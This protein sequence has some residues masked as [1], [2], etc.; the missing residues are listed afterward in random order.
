MAARRHREDTPSEAVQARWKKA[1]SQPRPAGS[2][3]FSSRLRSVPV[4]LALA[5]SLLLIGVDHALL[6]GA[7]E[8]ASPGPRPAMSGLWLAVLALAVGHG[9][10]IDRYLAL[11]TR[12]ER[13]FRLW[14]R[15]LRFVIA[16]LPVIGLCAIPGWR[17]LARK[18][19]RWAAGPEPS[20]DLAPS[21]FPPAERAIGDRTARETASD[22]SLTL[23]IIANV[24]LLFLGLPSLV[25]HIPRTALAVVLHL[26]VFAS[27]MPYVLAE[28]RRT[29]TARHR[30]AL[31]MAALG[32]TLVPV[33]FVPLG[34]LVAAVFLTP[35]AGEEALIGPVLE[36][37]H[38][39]S[40]A[41]GPPPVEPGE[42]ELRHELL[43]HRKIL[44]LPLEAAA[45]GWLLTHTALRRPATAE[46]LSSIL[47]L[48]KGATLILGA[49]GLLLMLLQLL[50]ALARDRI[51]W[52]LPAQPAYGRALAATQLGTYA[53][54]AI[55]EA[56]PRGDGAEVGAVI[57]VFGLLGLVLVFL[58]FFFVFLPMAPET[59]HRER[60]N[61]PWLLLFL[62]LTSMGLE[63]TR[64]DS[65]RE[66]AQDLLWLA[67]ILALVFGPGL[68]HQLL[69]ALLRPFRSSDTLRQ[70]LPRPL[71]G[72]ISF[73]RLTAILPLGGLAVPVWI[74]LRHHCRPRWTRRWP[75][76]ARPG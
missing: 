67:I 56:L 28:A 13:A 4:V 26:G 5:M 23:W 40:P 54:L 59:E 6:F 60:F 44:L 27:C 25:A 46:A 57:A 36:R 51:R 21:S 50:Q 1:R 75:P 58:R 62:G 34:G 7:P 66:R 70:E 22:R 33:P 68:G 19:P 48:A 3:L 73:L 30:G 35:R 41:G 52:L 61:V 74:Y 16:S 42:I 32:L 45:L 37:R 63:M 39:L 49:L 53:G 64:S 9:L 15:V 76:S 71:R 12:G 8:P 18:R 2:W 43:G 10:L 65:F 17:W 55:G 47:T 14:V 29:R 11:E 31:A 69:P 24:L 20:L 38:R 72:T